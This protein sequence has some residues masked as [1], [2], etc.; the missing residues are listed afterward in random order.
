M[1][2]AVWFASAGP[3]AMGERP[4]VVR[5]AAGGYVA[6]EVGTVDGE[7]GG[8]L[9][10]ATPH[11]GEPLVIGLS[12]VR[13]V[14]YVNDANGD[15]EPAGGGE[16]FDVR[17]CDGTRCVS[18][19]IRWDGSA[20][21]AELTPGGVDG[22]EVRLDAESVTSVRRKAEAVD[23]SGRTLVPGERSVWTLRRGGEP[24][25]PDGDRL[26]VIELD[27]ADDVA[28]A[29]VTGGGGRRWTVRLGVA[30]DTDVRVMLGRKVPAIREGQRFRGRGGAADFRRGDLEVW[31]ALND[32]SVEITRVEGTW[33]AVVRSTEGRQLKVIDALQADD[34]LAFH[35]D[36]DP[37][38]ESITLRDMSE[39]TVASFA[40][41]PPPVEGAREAFAVP[42]P[43]GFFARIGGLVRDVVK[44][45]SPRVNHIAIV[46]LGGRTAV[47]EVVTG[48]IPERGE[49]SMEAAGDWRGWSP[50]ERIGPPRPGESDATERW[51]I[52]EVSSR[53]GDVT[54]TGVV[55]RWDE[56]RVVVWIG[57]DEGWRR[58]ELEGWSAVRVKSV[59]RADGAVAGGDDPSLVVRGPGGQ[60]LHLTTLTADEDGYLGRLP[61]S[62]VS[63]RLPAGWTESW[64][65][66][67]RFIAPELDR[68][69]GVGWLSVAG[70]DDGGAARL[71]GRWVIDAGGTVRFVVGHGGGGD[72]DDAE[73]MSLT[74]DFRG[75]WTASGEVP[76]VGNR[77]AKPRRSKRKVW[78]RRGRRDRAT[79]SRETENYRLGGGVVGLRTGETLEA[80]VRSIDSEMAEVAPRVA[81]GSEG[82]GSV[83]VPVDQLSHVVFG[84]GSLTLDAESLGRLRT[85]P[86]SMRQRMPTHAL[87]SRGG[88]VV[89]GWLMSVDPEIV[90]LKVRT[91]TMEVPRG[92]LSA[93]VWLSPPGGGIEDG[94]DGE[95]REVGEDRGG[96]VAD[97]VVGS[98]VRFL[99][100]AGG[101]VLA[102]EPV[103]IDRG[104][105]RGRHPVL[106]ESEWDLEAVSGFD[107]VPAGSDWRDTAMRRGASGGRDSG[108][109]SPGGSSLAGGWKL[110]VAPEPIE[111]GGVAPA[112]ASPWVGR[113]APEVSLPRLGGGRWE[114]S[115]AR[116]KVLV[117]DFWA[118]WCGPCLRAMPV[119]EGVLDEFSPTDVA[120]IAVNQQESEDDAAAALERIGVAVDV[121]MDVDGVAA[122][123][124]RI[125][126][127]PQTFVVD[128]GGVVRAV[129]VGAGED[130]GEG[131]RTAIRDALNE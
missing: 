34:E 28:T 85:L 32:R 69:A 53:S 17:T 23:R 3:T 30:E 77:A 115:S 94:E 39:Q 11:F 61:G 98:G 56:D 37:E 18:P 45:A 130:L 42:K 118:G 83:R 110:S 62:E 88:D 102:I 54:V 29:S 51:L 26:S 4:G 79:D 104:R 65:R 31:G 82:E 73:A 101:G 49:V 119:V 36:V 5:L 107:V 68:D 121:A 108:G 123:R 13:S 70:S 106:G 50:P 93:V 111:P 58:R 60:R 64:F 71:P 57:G 12:D 1:W 74:G 46:H 122:Q 63:S 9:S 90:R 38:G 124:Y 100:P 96:N 76:T 41:R 44:P 75:S 59:R 80:D 87:V 113:P 27:R 52:A 95:D 47:R 19:T 8:A 40:W 92:L 43:A 15:G 24:R 117:M 128:R 55:Q 86:R 7:G 105:L 2:F 103:A 125:D 66:S 22:G 48:G 20:L 112:V 129:F 14:R 116:G 81:S 10:V 78:G 131:L 120:L 16:R 127:I 99:M 97:A 67:E 72:D 6:G 33:V 114:A 89:R 109:A 25:K 126:A 91:E 84:G 35:V 21:V